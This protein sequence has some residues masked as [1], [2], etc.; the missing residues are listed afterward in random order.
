M[1]IEEK[2][3]ARILLENKIHKCNGQ[4]FE[5][6]FTEIMSYVDHDFRK[7][8]AW[9][10]IGDRKND[11]Y[12]ESKGIYYQVY[13][14]ED[15]TLKYPEL[16]SKLKQDF[17][18]LKDQ[19]NPIKE[20]Y[21]VVNDKFKGVNADSEKVLKQLSTI[22][23]LDKS[24]FFTA[25]NLM[26]KVFSLETDEIV[27]IVGFLPNINNISKLDFSALNQVIPHIMKIPLNSIQEEIKRPNWDEKIK[28]NQ[29]SKNT[30]FLLNQGSFL[31]GSLNNY[32]SN[33]AFLAQELQMHMSSIYDKAKEL[34]NHPNMS[35]EN[36]FWEIVNMCL[37]ENEL[38]YQSA[39]I[40]IMSK[41]FESCDIF[42]EPIK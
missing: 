27:K 32:L 22:H 6:L 15:I 31:L 14:P 11:G 12:I 41:Y 25:D 20:F 18:G 13:A 3:L 9:G 21:F 7:I 24:G 26:Q 8:K 33:N 19:W 5:D 10:N 2:S 30:E 23:N 34:L 36:V 28:F 29:L 16:V 40:V 39:V 35:N 42:E 38:S 1:T 4:S 37:P 17:E